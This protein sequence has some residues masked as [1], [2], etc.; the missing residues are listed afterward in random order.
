VRLNKK[1]LATLD[2]NLLKMFRRVDEILG[3]ESPVR[4]FESMVNQA[5]KENSNG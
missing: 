5:L 3:D 4:D 1:L 2:P